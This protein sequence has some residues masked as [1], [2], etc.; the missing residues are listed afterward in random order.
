MTTEWNSFRQNER[1]QIEQWIMENGQ[2]VIVCCLDW[3]SGC[4]NRR[5]FRSLLYV[6]GN[7]SPVAHCDKCAEGITADIRL[8]M[9]INVV[10]IW[11][12]APA[13]AKAN[14]WT[15]EVFAFQIGNEDEE[16]AQRLYGYWNYIRRPTWEEWL[17]A[18][19]SGRRKSWWR[20]GDSWEE[21]VEN[22]KVVWGKWTTL[23]Y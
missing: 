15:F 14:L 2:P 6:V 19:E 10:T 18:I 17:I 8:K 21:N 4:L 9:Q 1:K 16:E 23:L 20:I 22:G 3:S 13:T 11:C 12:P 7:K 5:P